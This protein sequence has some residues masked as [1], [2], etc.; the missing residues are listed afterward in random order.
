MHLKVFKRTIFQLIFSMPNYSDVHHL[1][2]C[3][4]KQ[5]VYVEKKTF[6]FSSA[7]EKNKCG[8][9]SKMSVNQKQRL[10]RSQAPQPNSVTDFSC[11][12]LAAHP[13]ANRRADSRSWLYLNNSDPS[14]TMISFHSKMCARG[15]PCCS[16]SFWK[17]QVEISAA[18]KATRSLENITYHQATG[19]PLI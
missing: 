8:M 6:P 3:C 5:G 12:P 7:G 2:W 11:W 1:Y 15:L 10:L 17:Q 19:Q 13:K 9:N 4:C 14:Q 16:D 18:G